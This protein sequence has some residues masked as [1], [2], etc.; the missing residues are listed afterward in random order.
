MPRSRQLYTA[1]VIFALA[2]LTVQARVFWRWS[3]RGDTAHTLETLGGAQAYS[4][5][6]T[7]NGGQGQLDVFSFDTPFPTTLR[8]IGKALGIS[9]GDPTGRSMA[10]QT[11][12]TAG[13]RV[14]LIMVA[15]PDVTRTLVF[16]LQQSPDQA[17]H[18][19]AP[20]A[21]AALPHVPVYPGSTPIFDASDQKAHA[22]LAVAT[23]PATPQA[24]HRFYT[25]QL[26]AA[27]W[28]PAIE[29]SKDATGGIYLRERSVCCVH[30]SSQD[31]KTH[32]TI[33]HKELTTRPEGDR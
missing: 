18:S 17:R 24:V 20:P 33:L 26:G 28:M 10:V 21:P 30:A 23:T 11:I 6:V 14:R 19:Q 4:A 12:T 29:G 15:P 27:G 32:I 13:A 2:G 3:G 22:A 5:P 16:A 9:F 7:L 1:L 8:A 31:R 25:A